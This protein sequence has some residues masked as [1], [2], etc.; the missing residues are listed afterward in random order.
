MLGEEQVATQHSSRTLCAQHSLY[1]HQLRNTANNTLHATLHNTLRAKPFNTRKYSPRN[2]QHTTRTIQPQWTHV[3]SLFD[4]N[5]IWI[6]TWTSP[7]FIWPRF[8]PRSPSD[9]IGIFFY[10]TFLFSIF[11]LFKRVYFALLLLFLPLLFFLFIL[12]YSSIHSIHYPPLFYSFSLCILVHSPLLYSSTS[13][14]PF[15]YIYFPP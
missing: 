7:S 13:P 4:V 14:Y 2:T 1:A 10:F 15:S 6:A 8:F 11:R 5:Y 12:L 3:L 9:W